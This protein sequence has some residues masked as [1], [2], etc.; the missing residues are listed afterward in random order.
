MPSLLSLT[1]KPQLRCGPAQFATQLPGVF[2]M[3]F[4]SCRDQDCLRVRLAAPEVPNMQAG[5]AVSARLTLPTCGSWRE[6]W[7]TQERL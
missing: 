3:P 4:C 6:L 5:H 2:R 7:V 1:R